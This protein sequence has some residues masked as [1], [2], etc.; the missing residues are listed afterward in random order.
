MGKKNIS[1][2]KL[3]ELIAQYE[4]AKAEEKQ[5]YLDADQLAEIADQ[6][7]FERRFDEAQEVIIYG[8]KLHPGNTEL[9]M[10]QAYL[11]LDLQ[12]VQ[13][14]K[15]TAETITESYDT[16]VKLLKAEILLHEGQLEATKS[17]L[18]TI[19]EQDEMDTI[20]SIA[21]L[22]I[23]MGYPKEASPWLQEGLK[24]YSDEEEFLGVMAEYY[25]AI[26]RF[27]EAAEYY[28]ALIDMDAYNPLYWTILAKCRFAMEEYEKAIEACD[29]AL[30]ANPKFGEA[31]VFRAHSY[32]HLDNPDPAIADYKVAMEY[33]MMAPEFGYMFIGLA[34]YNKEDWKSAH[35]YYHRVIDIYQEKGEENSPL[36]VDTY[37][38]DALCLANMDMFEEAY[39]LCDKAK[40]INPKDTNIYLIE[41]KLYMT[42]GKTDEGNQAWA[43]AV[44]YSPEAETWFQIGSYS[45][46]LTMIKNAKFCF[47]Q[48]YDLNPGMNE[49]AEN[50]AIISLMLEDM[51]SFHKYNN[52]AKRP[53]TVDTIKEMQSY[54]DNPEAIKALRNVVRELT[55]RQKDQSS[56]E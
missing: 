39:Q 7:S 50:L 18:A 56:E 19:D 14:A 42:E 27:E 53:I 31:Y 54:I 3:T 41:G 16:D 6:Y 55:D 52:E 12:Q 33:K 48:A 20:I 5:I 17:I 8:L 28:N 43:N 32:F 47:E 25:Y 1:S 37:T 29:F 46:D 13:L 2:S 45:M 26:E 36:L 30:A 34:Y 38:N 4:A 51:D 40:K 9:L 15:L 22:Y 44:H 24:K 11:Y 49:L 10:E 35:E 21:Y 23:D